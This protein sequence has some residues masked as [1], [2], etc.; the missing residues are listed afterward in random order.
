MESKIRLVGNSKGVLLPK[1]I[2]QQAWLEAV[3][4]VNLTVENGAIVLRAAEPAPRYQ[5]RAGL[6]QAKRPMPSLDELK[7]AAE[8]GMAERGNPARR[9]S[10]G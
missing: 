8:A 10:A 2:L 4:R 3:E 7:K 9:G 1:A 5:S 6:I